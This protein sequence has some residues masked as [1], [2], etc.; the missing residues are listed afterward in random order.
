MASP[1]RDAASMGDEQQAALKR[2]R[3]LPGTPDP[4]AEVIAL[5]PR[6]LM[7]TNR[8][9]CEV[10]GKGFQR[11]QNLQLHRRGHN[12]P[13]K[14]KQREGQEIK[15]RVYVCPEATCIHHDPVRALGDLTG[16][17][18][19]FSR[20]HGEKKWKC[21]KCAKR[22]AVHSDWKAH[23]KVCGTREYR[24]DC[25]TLFSRRDS[26]ITHRA[27]C[28]ALAEENARV[29]VHKMVEPG[30]STG[31]EGN[32]LANAAGE[33]LDAPSSPLSQP[34]SGE[35]PHSEV[36]EPLVRDGC[37]IAL[38]ESRVSSFTSRR[39]PGPVL[40]LCL[41]T[42]L[43]PG[44]PCASDIIG[45]LRQSEAKAASKQMNKV[46]CVDS[47]RDERAQWPLPLAS[48]GIF[49]SM[50][51]AS[52]SDSESQGYATGR[53]TS[54]GMVGLSMGM[55]S[56]IS[57]STSSQFASSTYVENGFISSK[58][59]RQHTGGAQLPATTLLQKAAMMGSTKS[60]SFLFRNFGLARNS[61]SL[62]PDESRQHDSWAGVASSQSRSWHSSLSTRSAAEHLRLHCGPGYEVMGARGSYSTVYG[63]Q[64]SALGFRDSCGEGPA[65]LQNASHVASSSLNITMLDGNNNH[66]R[67]AQ[68]PLHEGSMI[69][70]GIACTEF[71]GSQRYERHEANRMT[72]DFLGVGGHSRSAGV[73]MGMEQNP[74]QR[75]VVSKNLLIAGVKLEP[76]IYL[77]DNMQARTGGHSSAPDC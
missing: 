68:D 74:S 49:T 3:N 16:I 33:L 41:G 64:E 65:R 38:K 23:Q 37:D 10:C 52:N 36:L 73:A 5:S 77:Q 61:G 50:L 72:L 8:F 75:D 40:S 69:Q 53:Y 42:G 11:D 32:A 28:E 60:S 66:Q 17:K 70:D 46:L 18:K 47:E 12:L 21:E 30:Q 45:C 31:P 71:E 55:N 48:A 2:K 14:L 67:A 63:G 6:T 19:H 15:K 44:P 4:Q 57:S 13:W 56:L 76:L 1:S 59:H 22:Y 26:F 34:T 25:G 39:V 7:A 35:P 54:N 9:L 43:G 51:T 27:F 29:S 58:R 62:S 20:K 24:C